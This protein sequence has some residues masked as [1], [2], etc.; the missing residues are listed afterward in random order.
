MGT[1]RGEHVIPMN[2][3]GSQE[4]SRVLREPPRKTGCADRESGGGRVRQMEKWPE[5][6]GTRTEEPE[7]ECVT[8]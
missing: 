6:E 3:G 5:G 8:G 1:Y 7:E 2:G 4:R